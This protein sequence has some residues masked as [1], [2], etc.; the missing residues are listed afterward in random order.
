MVVPHPNFLAIDNHNRRCIILGGERETMKIR[1]T[2]KAFN[3][4][5]I[6]ELPAIPR[7]GD[8]VELFHAPSPTVTDVV[9]LTGH[10]VE[11]QGVDVLILVE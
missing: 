6:I 11:K 10:F 5:L 8:R 7:I 4:T 1:V 3:K 2:H 9:W